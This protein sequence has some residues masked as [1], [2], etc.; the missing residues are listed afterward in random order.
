MAEADQDGAAFALAHLS[1]V[2]LGPLPAVGLRH[3]NLKRVLGWLNWQYRRRHVYSRDVLDRLVDDLRVQAPDH[4]A[5][6]GDLANLGLPAEHELALDW[7]GTLGTPDRVTV[8]PGNHD[9]YSGIGADLGTARWQPYMSANTAATDHA[10]AEAMGGEHAFPFVRRFGKLAIIALN[11]AVP[12]L[13][14]YAIGRLGPQQ[15]DQLAK[16]LDRLG[17]EG[18]MRVVLI[19]HPPLPGLSK[20]RH[21]LEDAAALADVLER[22]GA[23]LV[24]HGHE[25]SEMLAWHP[26]HGGRIPIIGVPSA[27]LAMPYKQEPLARYNLYRLLP[28]KNRPR[29]EM[30]ARGLAEPNGPVVELTRKWIDRQLDGD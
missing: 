13:P 18:M 30:I 24:L 19:H 27:S 6:T 25:H 26:T 10:I 20:P 4:I 2:H 1:D 14:F 8:I 11:S 15:L 12:T 5:V 22:H 16:I 9:I 21:D 23:E 17:A 28:G 7:L 29:I 3:W